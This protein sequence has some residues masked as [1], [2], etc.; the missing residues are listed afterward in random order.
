MILA[1]HQVYFEKKYDV[2]SMN[3]DQVKTLLSA[4]VP[5]VKGIFDYY[6]GGEVITAKMKDAYINYRAYGGHWA[7]TATFLNYS[8][9]A[10]VSIVWKDGAYKVTVA[11]MVF[12]AGTL[13]SVLLED[14]VTRKKTTQFATG[15]TITKSLDYI[16]K[17]LADLFALKNKKV[18][19]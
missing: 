5:S 9:T 8:F 1:N 3:V 14:A 4:H 10:T 17:Y 11:N 13:G 15:N 19:W 7:S 6:N 16:D 12:T 18:E 2:D